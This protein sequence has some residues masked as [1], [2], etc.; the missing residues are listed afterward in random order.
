[1]TPRQNEAR[2]RMET[3]ELREAPASVTQLTD[4]RPLEFRIDGTVETTDTRPRAG[5][6]GPAT[7]S[8]A[9]DFFATGSITYDAN[10]AG[11]SSTIKYFATGNGTTEFTTD[12]RTGDGNQSVTIDYS[13]T[14]TG[15]FRIRDNNGVWTTTTPFSRVSN[16]TTDTNTERAVLG[17]SG[18]KLNFDPST[19]SVTGGWAAQNG[20]NATSGALTGTI[21]QPGAKATD[22]SISGMKLTQG[23]EGYQASFNVGVTGALMT[24]PE[25]GS[26]AAI[27]TVQWTDGT[28][29]TEDAGVTVDVAWNAGKVT[30]DVVGLGPPEWATGV[31]VVVAANGWTE[32]ATLSNNAGA[33]DLGSAKPPTD[34][35]QPADPVVD[36]AV[37]TPVVGED[38]PATVNVYGPNGELRYSVTPYGEE[39]RGAISVAA[40]DVNGD[41]V[42]DIIT[43]AGA[44]GGPHV[45]IFDGVSGDEIASFFAYDENFRGGVNVAAGDI[46]GDGKADIVTGAGAG[47]AAH[48]K[49]FDFTSGETRRSFYAFDPSTSNGVNVAAVDFDNDGQAEI[50]TGSGSGDRPQVRVYDEND[51]EPLT[52]F[53]PYDSTFRTGAIVETRKLADGRVV[54][55]T[56][57]EFM[58]G[59]PE[60]QFDMTGRP[61]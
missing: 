61:V 37:R 47:G 55:V 60:L 25:K 2:P 50:V 20:A 17:P 24:S 31:K 8:F 9:G 39:W 59:M 6:V 23:E 38:G 14:E 28:G 22:L 15:N 51:A 27:A 34:P 36:P 21:T 13:A 43:G 12:G 5:A 19:M 26:P 4:Y 3:L 16:R 52:A 10:G 1:M 18:V 7:D 30:A 11:Q 33:A 46:D 48:V 29:R 35:N 53:E 54:I 41:G 32:T 44:G 40:G 57:A 58:Y 56:T 42:Q 49:V 45:K